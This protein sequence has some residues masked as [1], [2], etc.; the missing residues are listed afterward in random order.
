MVT[1]CLSCAECGGG[2]CHDTRPGLVN[3]HLVPHSHDDTGWLKTVDQ[4]YYGAKQ[5][6][7]RA[8]VQYIIESVIKELA[9]DPEKRFIQVET[10][11]FWR[12]WETQSEYMRNITRTL[13]DSG[14]LVFTGGGWSMNDEAVTHYASIIDNMETGLN[15]LVDTLGDCAVPTI[16]W[17]IDPFG[18]SKEQARLFAEMGFKGVFFA[19]IDYQDKYQR[20][21]DRSLQMWWEGGEASDNASTIFA[22]VFDEHYSNPKGFCWDIL[23]EDEPIN[24]DPRLEEYNLERTLILFENYVNDHINYY[25]DQNHIMFT[26]GDDFQYQNARMNFKNMDKLIKHMNEKSDQTGIH[27]LYSTPDCYLRAI[28]AGDQTETYPRKGRLQ[29]RKI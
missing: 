18:H 7:Q 12:W 21:M 25:K 29:S 20:K 15:W 8:G 24:D 22:G 13:V 3:V 6:V 5:T 16:A 26:M 14:Q 23:C 4:Y 1:H 10:G 27:L 17:Q 2:G 11:F 19:R 28:T 9:R